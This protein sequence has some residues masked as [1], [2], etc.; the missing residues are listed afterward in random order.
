MRKQSYL[1]ARDARTHAHDPVLCREKTVLF[2][3]TSKTSRA[4]TSER[5]GSTT[6]HI[7]GRVFLSWTLVR[8]LTSTRLCST[9]GTRRA[10]AGSRCTW[11]G[12]HS[13]GSPWPPHR[14][15][16]ILEPGPG[17]RRGVRGCCPP[18]SSDA[19]SRSV[20]VHLSPARILIGPAGDSYSGDDVTVKR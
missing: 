7:T 4:L 19:K 11:V 10:A 3:V 17:A 20:P 15:G 14:S 18:G 5:I 13:S 1:N 2:N 16:L 8:V 6:R 12:L 9:A